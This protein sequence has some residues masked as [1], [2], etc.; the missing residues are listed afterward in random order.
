MS[1][2]AVS[3]ASLVKSNNG[4]FKSEAQAKFL[5]SQCQEENTFVCGGNVYNNSFTIFYICDSLG[6]VK[7]EKYLP[8]SG[9]TTTTWERLTADQFQA[10]QEAKATSKARDIALQE[11]SVAKWQVRQDAFNNALAV[12]K[13]YIKQVMIET[14]CPEATAQRAVDSIMNNQDDINNSMETLVKS[15]EFVKAWEV[16]NNEPGV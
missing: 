11:A 14:G 5:L 3:F 6:V 15:S 7:V 4:M 12:A 2:V 10:S 16:Y 1:N 8:K 9:K 13:S